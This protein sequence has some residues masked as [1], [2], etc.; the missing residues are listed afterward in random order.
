MESLHFAVY[1]FLPFVS[2][3]LKG[4]D[5]PSIVGG[6]TEKKAPLLEEQV[7]R[8]RRLVDLLK[9]RL[10]VGSNRHTMTEEIGKLLENL[11]WFTC[12]G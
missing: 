1:M 10:D 2:M 7:M 11:N 12:L 8:A 4:E 6:I 3:F 5:A 9:D